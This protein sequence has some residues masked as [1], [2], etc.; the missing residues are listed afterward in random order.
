MPEHASEHEEI[1]AAVQFRDGSDDG[2]ENPK[3][4]QRTMVS[5]Y[6]L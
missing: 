4:Q 1:V 6:P 3:S 2:Q 5:R